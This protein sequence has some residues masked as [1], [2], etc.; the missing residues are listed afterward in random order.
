[1]YIKIRCRLDDEPQTF[2]Y[3]DGFPISIGR[4]S[5]CRLNIPD[6]PDYRTVSRHHVDI[7]VMEKAFYLCNLSQKNPVY[8]NNE[9]LNPRQEAPLKSGDIFRL[10]QLEMEIVDISTDR[11][12][13]HKVKCPNGHLVEYTAQYCPR[14]GL[15]IETASTA[16]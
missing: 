9:Q 12:H 4:G 15:A 14:C 3:S 10:G 1:M 6:E 13:R 5:K 16:F 7:F 8:L 2:E 11:K